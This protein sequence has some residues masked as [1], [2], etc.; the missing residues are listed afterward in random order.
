MVELLPFSWE[1]M[2][3]AVEDV[4]Q[5]LLRATSALEAAKVPYAVIGG[6]AVAAWV[7]RVDRDAARNTKDVD[8]LM[9]RN[10]LDAATPVLEACGFVRVEVLGVPMFLDGPNGK[11]S[12]AV[13]ILIAKEKVRPEYVAAAPDIDESEM[14]EQFRT[15]SLE[16]LVR[17]KLTSF[18]DKDRTHIRDLIGVGLID[19]SWP[20]CFQPEL[21]RRLQE[22]LDNPDG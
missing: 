14:L 16:A 10:D 3:G 15:I 8:I 22:I 1:R 12:Q 4:R 21:A 20:N 9:R 5:R 11:P 18:R 2:I 19:A 7:S 6:N 13:H 17:M